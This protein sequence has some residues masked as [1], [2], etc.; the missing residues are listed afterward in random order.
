M[1]FQGRKRVRDG[2]T[3]R[4]TAPAGECVLSWGSGTAHSPRTRDLPEQVYGFPA[5]GSEPA[6]AAAGAATAAPAFARPCVP[7]ADAVTRAGGV[8]ATPLQVKRDP[9]LK[10]ARAGRFHA[11]SNRNR[12]ESAGLPRDAE[13]Q[14]GEPLQEH[15]GRRVNHE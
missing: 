8:A 12:A 7:P 2:G 11:S 6:T 14:R 3:Y 1:P 5:A 10:K 9:Q 15:G 13:L 4:S